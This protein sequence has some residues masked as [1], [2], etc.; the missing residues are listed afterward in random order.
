MNKIS[1]FSLSRMNLQQKISEV[2]LEE[3]AAFS[4]KKIFNEVYKEKFQS[5]NFSFIGLHKNV[6]NWINN[7]ISFENSVEIQTTH[8]SQEDA[9]VKFIMQLKKDCLQIETVLIPEPKR[10]T[11]CVSTQVGCAQGCRFCQT[12]RMGLI[13]SL[14]TDEIVGQLIAVEKWKSEN[15]YFRKTKVTNVVYMGMGEPLDNIESVIESTKIFCDS[16]AFFLSHNKVTVSTVGLLP[17]LN[18]ILLETPVCVALSL[19]SPFEEERSKVMPVNDRHH[20]TDIISILKHHLDSGTRKSFLVQYTLIRGVNDTEKHAHKLIELLSNYNFKI[21][22]IPLNEHEGTAYR[23]P[24]L[25]RVYSFQQQLKN[26]GLV[27]TI[28]LSKGRDIAAACG[29]LIKKSSALERK[30]NEF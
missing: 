18:K 16:Q 12:G 5:K 26:S 29:Q 1:F 15:D 3:K 14:S 20:L 30:Q 8:V 11:L 21:N 25:G 19:H 22:L 23:R 27:A 10:L 6:L 7:N 17:Q 24:D 4:A 28:R 13:R 9:S 2:Y